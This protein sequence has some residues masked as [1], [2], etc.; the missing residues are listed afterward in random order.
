MPSEPEAERGAA[1]PCAFFST[2]PLASAPRS[3]ERCG[4]NC[5][6]QDEL[7]CALDS[8][9]EHL[10]TGWDSSSKMKNERVEK[11]VEAREVGR[12]LK[13]GVEEWCPTPA[14]RE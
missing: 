11:R 5:A 13:R 1:R 2:A 6:P 3:V 12:S 4:Y 7:L 14:Y 10:S 9:L 8:S